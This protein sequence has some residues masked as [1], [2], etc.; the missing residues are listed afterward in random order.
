MVRYHLE[1][2]TGRMCCCSPSL[3]LLIFPSTVVLSLIYHKRPYTNITDLYS[4]MVSAF[5][6]RTGYYAPANMG[7]I[8]LHFLDTR[9]CDLSTVG[10]S[11]G[12]FFIVDGCELGSRL[13]FCAVQGSLFLACDQAVHD[14]Q[15]ATR[16]I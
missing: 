14:F 2:V 1:Q 3:V 13:F 6:S 15:M 5:I 12:L 4:L 10:G 7:N 11:P 16:C 9:G 8:G